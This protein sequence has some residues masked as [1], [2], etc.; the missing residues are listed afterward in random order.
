MTK[1]YIATAVAGANH[2]SRRRITLEN[3]TLADRRRNALVLQKIQ[4]GLLAIGVWLGRIGT[5]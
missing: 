2:E 5:G 3:P 1:T 4:P